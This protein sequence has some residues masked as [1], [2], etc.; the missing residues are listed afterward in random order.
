MKKGTVLTAVT[1]LALGVIF[2]QIGHSGKK[3]SKECF[4]NSLH[5]T[6]RGMKHWYNSQKGFSAITKTPYRELGCKN[7]HTASCNDCH[8]SETDAG[9]SYSLKKARKSETCLKCHSRERATISIDK[10]RDSLGVHMQ[11]SMECADCH[12]A[13][14]VH[15][16]GECYDSMRAPDAMDT[17]CE[18]CHT[19]DST[20]YPP[21]PKTRSHSVHRDKL[22]CSA[23]HVQNSMTCYNC[24]FGQLKK[25]KSKPQS[26]V[27][28]AKDFLL[29]VKYEGKVTS[30]TMQ[31]LVGADDYP[32]IAY[33]PYLTH[34]I[35][36]EGRKCE[37]CHGNKAVEKLAAGEKFTPASYTNGKMEFFQGV[38]PVAPN[39]LDWPFLKK[40]GNKWTTF[41]PD[42]EPL[43]QM[44]VYANPLNK[45]ELRKMAMEFK[46][47]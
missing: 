33:V 24:H 39:Y 19:K 7:C 1:V 17:E 36:A 4:K 45:K 25:T 32:F 29:L 22:D 41:K 23:C 42:H 5:Y 31:S 21:I 14:E 10:K 26:M 11:A 44:G 6:T 18:N 43:I 38:I 15:G 16:D 47:R 40:K 46:S 9:F 8:L 28:K 35:S 30:G 12:S 37:A 27:T 34:S 13:R 3:A 2:T 20:E